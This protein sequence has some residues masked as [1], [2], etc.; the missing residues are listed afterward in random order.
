VSGRAGLFGCSAL[1]L[2][3]GCLCFPLSAAALFYKFPDDAFTPIVLAI[4]AAFIGLFGFVLFVL[5]LFSPRTATGFGE[6]FRQASRGVQANRVRASFPVIGVMISVAA[7]I[8]LV[9]VGQGMKAGIQS[10]L[11]NLGK[12]VLQ[13]DPTTKSRIEN[14]PD[15][16]DPLASLTISTALAPGAK[17]GALQQSSLKQSD[18]DEL[19]K[20][21][22]ADYISNAVAMIINSEYVKVNDNKLRTSVYGTTESYQDVLAWKV[23][24]GI[25]NSRWFAD[26]SKNEVVIGS[27]VVKKLWPD[28]QKKDVIGKGITL[29]DGDL[30][31][32]DYKV[33][34]IMEEK[35]K[36]VATAQ[37]NKLFMSLD[38]ARDLYTGQ[39]PQGAK[40]DYGDRVD[41]IDLKFPN[42]DKANQIADAKEY[43][44]STL[45]ALKEKEPDATRYFL[46][47]DAEDIAKPNESIFQM[48][49]GALAGII[50]IALVEAGMGVLMI[51]YVSVKERTREI[52]L[53]KA[54]GATNGQVIGQFLMESILLCI[55]GAIIGVPIGIALS[56]L[57][58][59]GGMLTKIQ[60]WSIPLAIFSVFFV[61]VIAGLFPSQQAARVPP[62]E[63]M[64]SE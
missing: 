44:Q 2:L 52:G 11:G 62:V 28:L 33:A 35:E 12:D 54:S 17:A 36:G 7:V 15:K 18:I 46:I 6:V 42:P 1:A 32:H 58:N 13:I 56:Y 24:T 29:E 37:D 40:I 20:G 43:A 31:T 21:K 41:E 53:R 47:K 26:G 38:A 3:L 9:A 51:M 25:P 4:T 48:M 60:L 61:G 34:G 30:K 59:L 16:D 23:D 19:R 55:V 49:D 22:G 10:Q 50:M 5:T 8:I 63:A 39:T 45:S 57:I 27:T 64:R 14:P